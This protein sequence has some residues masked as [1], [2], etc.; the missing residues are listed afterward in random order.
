MTEE[1]FAPRVGK[2][3]KVRMPDGEPLHLGKGEGY[4]MDD[5]PQDG[6]PVWLTSDGE[7]WV[8]AIWRNTRK[9]DPRNGLWHPYAYWA[10]RN[11][12]G[13]AVEFTPSAWKPAQ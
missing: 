2:T 8:E 5:A 12:G 4:D 3:R 10:H 9:M 6:K 1:T 13:K 11:A 7:I